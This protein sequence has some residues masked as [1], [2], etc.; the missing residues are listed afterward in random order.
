MRI[1]SPFWVCLITVTLSG[2]AGYRVGPVNGETAGDK[3]VQVIPFTNRTLE[4]NLTDS[5]TTEVRRYVQQDGTYRL[6]TH[7]DGDIILSGVITA[8]NR[9]ELTLSA[10]ALSYNDYRI[11]ITATVTARS[12]ATGKVLFTQSVSGSTITQASSNTSGNGNDLNESDTNLPSAERQSLPVVS[13]NL[14]KNVV[15][16]LTEGKWW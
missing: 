2:C 11:T 9:Q 14:A 6:A 5:I 12:R 4:P 13:A 15:R 1:F 10:D 16:V 7:N 3:S 8:Y